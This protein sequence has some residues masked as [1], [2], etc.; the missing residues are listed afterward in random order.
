MK[1]YF[2]KPKLQYRKESV[3]W[4]DERIVTSFKFDTGIGIYEKS[5][6]CPAY[7][8]ITLFGFGMG[9]Q[10]GKGAWDG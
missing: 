3:N 10:I 1:F 8:T 7:V 5:E 6:D 9:I 2:L 4:G